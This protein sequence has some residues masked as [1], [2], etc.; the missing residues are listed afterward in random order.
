MK[1]LHLKHLYKHNFVVQCVS[2]SINNDATLLG[3]ILLLK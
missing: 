2:C 1:K 3:T